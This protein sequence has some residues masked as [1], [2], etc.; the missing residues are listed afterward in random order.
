MKI[1]LLSSTNNRENGYGNLTHQLCH[2]L[3]RAGI[4]ITLLLPK[5]EPRY[6]YADYKTEYVLPGY[7]FDMKTKKVLEY[8]T[9]S[10][11]TDADIIHSVIEFPYAILAARIALKYKKPLIIQAAGTYAVKPLHR[12]PDKYF[13]KWAYNKASVIA[14]ISKFTGDMIQEYSHTPT[15]M[16]IIHPGV[17]FD[18]FNKQID[19][20]DITAKYPR[21]KILL[22]VGVLKPR[23]GHDVVLRALGELKKKRDDFQYLIVGADNEGRDEYTASLRTIVKEN[24]LGNN[25]TFVGNVPD[26]DLVRYFH[27]SYLYIHTPKRVHWNF[28]GFGIVYL[29]AGAC[30]KPAVAADSGGIRDAVVDG[31]TGIV[32]PEGDYHATAQAIEKFLDNPALAM[33]MG[34]AGYEY[35]KK[36]DWKVIVEEFIDLYKDLL[37]KK[38][39]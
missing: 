22:T 24:N 26:V 15:L 17:H 19:S 31:K 39:S 36:H 28:E 34:N 2:F 8:A 1:L 38:S 27:S 12:F 16:K 23:K 25:V 13:L 29:E 35:A 9:F 30:R 21:K 32:V 6:A 37:S 10:Y 4:D 5:D 20:L 7:I 3:S 33:E 14:P 11:E 18:N